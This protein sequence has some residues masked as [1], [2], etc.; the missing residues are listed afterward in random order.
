MSAP[1]CSQSRSR[2]RESRKWKRY[3]NVSGCEFKRIPKTSR[4][5]Y[6]RAGRRKRVILCQELIW[7]STDKANTYCMRERGHEGKHNIENCEPKEEKK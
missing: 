1:V 2:R 5:D 4:R 3:L 6:R 7:T